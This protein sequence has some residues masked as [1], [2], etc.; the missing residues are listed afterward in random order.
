MIISMNIHIAGHFSQ[1]V[2]KNCFA[3]FFEEYDEEYDEEYASDFHPPHAQ[4]AWNGDA[5]F[6]ALWLTDSSKY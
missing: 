2:R 3:L 4:E 5:A 1:S 6:W